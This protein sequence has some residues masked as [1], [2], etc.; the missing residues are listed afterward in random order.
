MPAASRERM[1]DFK[2]LAGMGG[3]LHRSRT[4]AFLR[5][6]L[7]FPLQISPTPL[8]SRGGNDSV[9]TGISPQGTPSRDHRVQDIMLDSIR[10]PRCLEFYPSPGLSSEDGDE[11]CELAK[12]SMLV[13]ANP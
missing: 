10:G 8:N 12:L 2:A 1:G 4:P 9:E 5:L 7:S 11:E 13:Q 3:D 6:L